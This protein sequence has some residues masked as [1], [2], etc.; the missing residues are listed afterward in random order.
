M[1]QGVS[2]FSQVI[3]LDVRSQ[4]PA[5]PNDPT[6]TATLPPEQE[7][8]YPAILNKGEIP[9][10][11]LSVTSL[12]VLCGRGKYIDGSLHLFRL[13]PPSTSELICNRVARESL[14]LAQL[15]QYQETVSCDLIVMIT[16]SG[17]VVGADKVLSADRI[18]PGCNVRPAASELVLKGLTQ[19]SIRFELI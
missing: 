2:A 5:D 15:R 11:A 8:N 13:H 18:R 14:L 4:Q 16:T 10:S 19:L 17:S 1:F 7:I 3:S 9:G 12:H 6:A